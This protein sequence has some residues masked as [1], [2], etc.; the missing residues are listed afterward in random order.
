MPRSRTAAL[1]PI[2]FSHANSFP[3]GTYRKLFDAWRAAGH[4]V[5]AI[6][7]YGHDPRYPVSNHWPRLR[8]QLVHFAEREVGRPAW[9]VGHSLGGFLSVLAAAHR[10]GLALGV[11]MLD[12]PLLGG[13][14]GTMVNF[15]KTTGLGASYSPGTVSQRRRNHWP[16]PEAALAHFRAKAAFARWD[17]EVLQDYIAAGIVPA[18][19]PL[20]KGATLAFRREVETAIYNTLPHDIPRF[21]RTHPL[22]APVAFIGGT[23][24]AEVRQVGMAATERLTAGRISWLNG[25]HLFPFEHPD[26]T[27]AE[28]LAWITRLREGAAAPEGAGPRL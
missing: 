8:D 28:V 9:F 26:A 17:P 19:A 24:S 23:Q 3:A 20:P 25:T 2:V 27:A 16:S 10:P 6:D 1:P 21:L 4:E 5:V 14:V 18:E 15:A 12:S 11:V 22:Q 13:W 7:K